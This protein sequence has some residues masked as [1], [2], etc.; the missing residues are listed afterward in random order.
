MDETEGTV[1]VLEPDTDT[2]SAVSEETTDEVAETEGQEEGSETEPETY[3]AEDVEARIEAARKETEERIREQARE[4]AARFQAE[5]RNKELDQSWQKMSGDFLANYLRGAAA[6]GAKQGNE[7]RAADEV[8]N[9]YQTTHARQILDEFAKNAMPYMLK[10]VY[11]DLAG[12]VPVFLGKEFDDWTP[13]K[14]VLDKYHASMRS[15]DANTAFG[16][17]VEYIREAIESNVVPKK[18][19]E[20]KKSASESNKK[21]EA[22][23]NLQNPPKQAGP[24]KGGSGGTPP[25]QTVESAISIADKRKAFEEQYGIPFPG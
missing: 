4:E 2:E 8:A 7:G 6:W 11:D 21:G 16:G 10:K 9:L 5:Q 3:T 12:A 24:V 22:V 13:P 1:A 20:A 17:L 25:K 23:K 19:E 14:A 15:N 18:L